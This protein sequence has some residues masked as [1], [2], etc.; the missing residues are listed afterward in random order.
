MGELPQAPIRYLR[1][2]VADWIA[3]QRFTS[4]SAVSARTPAKADMC[5]T[6]A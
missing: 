2:D 3:S 1:S 4:T 5:G 6:R